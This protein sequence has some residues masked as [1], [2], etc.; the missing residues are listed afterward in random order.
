M[1]KMQRIVSI[2]IALYLLLVLID[3]FVLVEL[4]VTR[5]GLSVLLALFEAFAILGAGFAVRGA[6]ARALA[7][8]GGLSRSAIW[9]LFG[10][11]NFATS[12]G[13]APPAVPL[14]DCFFK[15]VR[16][17]LLAHHF[18]SSDSF[19]NAGG[20]CSIVVCFSIVVVTPQALAVPCNRVSGPRPG[21]TR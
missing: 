21:H 6:I 18:A 13:P 20:F 4:L 7:I 9:I 5:I 17:A 8:S 2:V 14:P 1:S 15:K 12:L 10:A 16:P 19:A 3:R 11:A